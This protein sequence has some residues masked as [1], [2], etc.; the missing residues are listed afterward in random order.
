[1]V[2]NEDPFHPVVKVLGVIAFFTYRKRSEVMSGREK[3]VTKKAV[4]NTQKLV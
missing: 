4:C 3:E 2:I 1:M